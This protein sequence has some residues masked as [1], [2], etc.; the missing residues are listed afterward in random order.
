MTPWV[1]R[2]IVANII[3]FFL[4]YVGGVGRHL[5]FV[6]AEFLQYPWTVIT[7]MFVHQ[8]VMHILFNMIS[9]YFFGPRVEERLGARRFL[10]LYFLSGIAGALLSAIFAPRVGI[11][12]AS[13]AVFGVMIAFAHFWPD[14]QI[15]IFGVLPLTARVAVILMALLA[16]YSGVQGS[17]TGVADFAH[18]GGF[19][20]G[21]LYVKWFD[22]SLGAKRFRAKAKPTVAKDQL[23]NWKRVD[24]KSVHEVNRDEVNRILDKISAKGLNSLTAEERLFLSNF[25][26]PDDRVPPPT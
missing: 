11:V 20:A 7:Y 19:V 21:W 25:V 8:G 16:L 13:G 14:V 12:G 26:P 24:P 17:R 22:M 3:V 4:E 2:L 6:P 10:T 18:L 15:Y 23:I 1:L 9:L 5:A